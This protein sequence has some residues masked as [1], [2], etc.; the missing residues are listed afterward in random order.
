LKRL[1]DLSVI[2]FS[3]IAIVGIAIPESEKPA[4]YAKFKQCLVSEVFF[5]ITFYEINYVMK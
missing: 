4:N 3:G 1:Y 2:F 5:I